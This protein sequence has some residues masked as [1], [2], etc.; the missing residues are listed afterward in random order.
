[1]GYRIPRR[2]QSGVCRASLAGMALVSISETPGGVKASSSL[3]SPHPLPAGERIKVRG[4]GGVRGRLLDYVVRPK[5]ERFGNR[6]AQ[7]LRR[8]Q[9]DHQ[10]EL[11]RLLHGQ[12]GWLCALQDLVH[13]GRGGAAGGAGGAPL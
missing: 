2:S 10:L 7:G 3:P 12:G 9:V 6:E 4:E 1:M 5:A 8:L 11:G 13:E